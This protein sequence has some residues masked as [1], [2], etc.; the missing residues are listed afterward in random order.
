MTA[1]HRRILLFSL[2]LAVLTAA[3]LLRGPRVQAAI[4]RQEPSGDAVPIS[5][6]VRI[7][8]QD[9]VKR[10]ETERSFQI[11]PATPGQFVWERKTLVFTPDRPLAPTSAY[12]VT[13]SPTSARTVGQAATSWAFH[14]RAPRLLS[15]A[16]HQARLIAS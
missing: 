10:P 2:A 7:T 12:T 9:Q 3:V 16:A 8:F 13:I 14:T 1:Y 5:A 11:V 6:S 4:A 15:L